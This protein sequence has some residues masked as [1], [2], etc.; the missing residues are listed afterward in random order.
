MQTICLIAMYT[1]M[2]KICTATTCRKS[3]PAHLI[4]MV[5]ITPELVQ[6]QE[7]KAALVP[8]ILAGL[9]IATALELEAGD[10]L[11]TAHLEAQATQLL[12]TETVTRREFLAKPVLA[13]S[14]LTSAYILMMTATILMGLN[15]LNG[16]RL[17]NMP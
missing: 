8:A 4:P 10:L 5:V 1:G 6:G 12:A 3:N 17:K 7:A 14:S 11:A 2:Q 13:L 16:C 15:K 9:A